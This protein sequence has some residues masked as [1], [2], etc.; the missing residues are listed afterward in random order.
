MTDSRHSSSEDLELGRL[1]VNSVSEHHVGARESDLVQVLDVAASG[2]AADE[3]GFT[4]ILVRVSLE[5]P[6]VGSREIAGSS[7]LLSPPTDIEALA[8]NLFWVLDD[9]AMHDKLA[10]R[11]RSNVNRFSWSRTADEMLALYRHVL[12]GD[13]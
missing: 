6:S 3:L 5:E 7:A 13:T 10:R 9:Q 2:V 1:Q 11:G 8:A 12:E 4:S